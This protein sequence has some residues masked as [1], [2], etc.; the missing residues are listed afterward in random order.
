MAAG[1][2]AVE[3]ALVVVVVVEAVALAVEEEG[4]EEKERETMEAAIEPSVLVVEFLV[5]SLP[6]MGT[7]AKEDAEGYSRVAP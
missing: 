1:T 5:G 4:E 3:F 6:W 2:F 7:A